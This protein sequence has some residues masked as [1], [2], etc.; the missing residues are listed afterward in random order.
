MSELTPN[1]GLFKYSTDLDGKQVFSI[2]TALNDNWDILDEKCNEIITDL[3]DKVVLDLSNANPSQT[4][5]DNT[6]TWNLPDWNAAVDITSTWNTVRAYTPPCNGII[7]GF[8]IDNNTF[9]IAIEEGITNGNLGGGIAFYNGIADSWIYNTVM[10]PLLAGQTYYNTDT[11]F[12]LDASVVKFY[13]LK[14][15]N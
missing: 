5:I 3:N 10:V 4:F 13:P 15:A 6:I 8:V 12:I 11:T 1:L 2:D 14:G 7:T 9:G